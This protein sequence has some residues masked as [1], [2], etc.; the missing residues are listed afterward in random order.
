MTD[1]DL[2][3]ALFALPLE[4]PPQ[5]LREAIL[6]A[7]VYAPVRV[8]APFS[9]AETIGI[10]IALALAAWIALICIADRNVVAGIEALAL[11]FVR[12]FSD[13][14]NIAWAGTGVL[15]AA[16]ISVAVSGPFQLPFGRRA[17]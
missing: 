13:V 4:E 6:R 17:S 12:A 16:W 9:V 3:R 15:A 1:D 11:S 14:R 7:T 5:G 2:D 10:G 8:S